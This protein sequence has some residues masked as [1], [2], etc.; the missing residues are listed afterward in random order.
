MN[1]KELLKGINYTLISGDLDTEVKDIKYD[2]RKVEEGDIFVAL[3]G[4]IVDGHDFIPEAILKKA[5][6][7]VMSKILQVHGDVTIIKVDDTRTALALLSKNYFG[8]PTDKLTVIGVTGTTGKTTT[9]HMIKQ[10]LEDAGIACG[11]IG[12]IGAKFKN[13]KIPTENTTPESYEIEYFFK[14]MVKH[15]I[16]HVVMETSSQAFK[17]HRLEGITFDIGV[18]TNLTSDHIGPTEHASQEEYIACKRE[19]FLNS[20]KVIINNDSNYLEEVL[21][22]VTAPIIRYGISNAADI[23]ATDIKLINDTY[24]FG[25]EFKAYGLVNDTFKTIMPGK[26]N[27]Y[28]SLCAICV[29]NELGIDVD[30][31]KKALLNLKVTGR[32][33]TAL[34]TP[35][36]KV[37]IDYAHTEDSMQKLVETLKEY[38]PKR[39]VSIFGG[40]GNRAKER[41]FKLGEI[42]GG[43]SDFSIITMDNPRFEEISKINEDIKVGLNKVN[44]KYI[45]IDDREEAINYAVK[46]AKNGDLILLVGKGHEN[47]QDIKGTKYYFNEHEILTKIKNNFFPS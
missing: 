36:I 1:L 34:I 45:E 19:L 4:F 41:R 42:I 23:N 6:V 26:F 33:E 3:P 20:R 43:T 27:I 8:S 32:M 39:L 21:K 30:S 10:M 17:M 40:G 9:T 24:F 37:I 14:E 44:A 18:L 31:M 11:L 38:H 35:K 16:T 46:N 12:S 15:G 7:I 22:N 5:S 25:S 29:C 2:S 13:I 28:N 47:Y